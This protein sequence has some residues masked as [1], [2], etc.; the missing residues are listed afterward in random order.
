MIAPLVAVDAD[1]RRLQRP[2]RPI[3]LRARRD[4]ARE[5]RSPALHGRM[6]S[7]EEGRDRRGVSQRGA[8]TSSSRR[9]SSRS[10]STSRTR[11]SWSS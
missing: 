8:S 10:A 9:P 6:K 4:A 7:A 11:R 1:E 5:S 2:P 3:A